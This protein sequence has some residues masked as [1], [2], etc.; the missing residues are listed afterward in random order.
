M[1]ELIKGLLLIAI[2]LAILAITVLLGA[3]YGAG[4]SLYN[5]AF[6]LKNNIKPEEN[7]KITKG[8]EPAKKNYFFEKG[9]QDL[10]NVINN[11]WEKNI[12][13][14]K[15]CFSKAKKNNDNPIEPI[16][17]W[18]AGISVVV[19]GTIFFIIISLFHFLVLGGFLL[20]LYLSF[21][22][23]WFIERAYLFFHR[24]FAACPY[25]HTKT[26]LPE[27][28]CDNCGA[29]HKKLVPNEY[30]I[31]YHTCECGHRLPSTFFLN[32]GR[33]QARCSNCHQF[34]LREHIESKR[35]FIPILGGPSAG[36]TT[37][38]FSAIRNLIDHKAKDLGFETEFIDKIAESKYNK[39]VNDL[40]SG[41]LPLKTVDNI[42]KAFN[43]AL[44]KN[45]AT[46]WLLYIYDPAGEAYSNADNLSSHYYSEYMS[47]MI[48]VIDPFTF[49]GVR[50]EYKN[51]LKINKK[52][53]G[54]SSL[55]ADDALT[56][57]ILAMEESFG[58][59][60]TGKIQKPLAVVITKVDALELED[61]IGNK[62]IDGSVK[63]K[64][65]AKHK[66]IKKQLLEWGEAALLH[67][68]ESRFS[69][70]R[71]FSSS[72]LGR[73]PD[74]SKKDLKGYDVL[75]PILWIA[76][77]VSDEEFRYE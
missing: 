34:L 53:I 71:F 51:Q 77:T 70:F 15:D 4:I 9:F 18:M 44:K 37:F 56:R 43:L 26:T 69:N 40:M 30:G 36:K 60:K 32:R 67:Q 47:G 57:T 52:G 16:M 49:R 29:I 74:G 73:I 61:T 11:N 65:F 42:P 5:Y 76:S 55:S 3:V 22:I 1:G 50:Q 58:L 28:L 13:S 12:D 25:C 27:Y 6:A 19:Y 8:L 59:K 39:I 21:S 24:F 20:L 10:I 14:S 41:H 66:L 17:W 7:V 54:P 63:D 33:L 2:G 23:V 72:A 35:L 45:N 46:K 48:F 68:L 31:F 75:E 38:M 62:A 64:S